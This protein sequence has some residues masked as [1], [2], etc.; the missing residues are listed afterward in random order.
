MPLSV[1]VASSFP[2]VGEPALLAHLPVPGIL[3]SAT[4][5]QGALHLTLDNLSQIIPD[6]RLDVKS[7]QGVKYGSCK[8]RYVL[9][10]GP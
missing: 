6:F 4:H 1:I 3:S 10:A 9:A 7:K 2:V 5:L 8:P